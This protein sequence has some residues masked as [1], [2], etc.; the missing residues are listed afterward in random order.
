MQD[1]WIPS[2]KLQAKITSLMIKNANGS[3]RYVYAFCLPLI[4]RFD[5]K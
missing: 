3:E 1:E 5:E 4:L 2:N